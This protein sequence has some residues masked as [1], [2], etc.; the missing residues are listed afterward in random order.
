MEREEDSGE[1]AP[2]KERAERKKKPF[3][4]PSDLNDYKAS[5][6]TADQG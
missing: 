3:S 2:L 5:V 6:K 4:K 1:A